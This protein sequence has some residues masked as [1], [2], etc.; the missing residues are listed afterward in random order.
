MSRLQDTKPALMA[1]ALTALVSGCTASAPAGNSAGPVAP[2]F[3]VPTA[4]AGL[5]GPHSV[6]GATG[7]ITSDTLP[8]IGPL[9]FGVYPY[10]PGYPTK[11][12]IRARYNQDDSL[13]LTGFLCDGDGRRLRFWYHDGGTPGA[14]PMTEQ[15]LLTAGDLI[16]SLRPLPAGNDHTGYFLFSTAGVWAVAVTKGS[17]Q[18]GVVLI[19]AIPCEQADAASC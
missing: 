11:T 3:A 10:H 8:A 13:T 19:D 2:S 15:Q 18:L 6:S 16:A 14:V 5:T 7:G 1:L 17:E 4:C 9:R 12:L